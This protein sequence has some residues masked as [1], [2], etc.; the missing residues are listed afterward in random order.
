LQTSVNAKHKKMSSLPPGAEK[1]DHIGIAVKDLDAAEKTYTQLLGV[2]PYKRETVASQQ[3]V[4]SFFK[5]GESKI[6]LLSPTAPESPIAKFLENK[7][8]G[9]HHLAFG[10]KDI[11]AS[12]AK[13]KAQGFRLIH[14][15]PIQGADQ[16][17][18]AFVHP[19]D[20]TGALIELCEPLQQGL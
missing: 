13:L 2:P 15:T 4:T 7:G 17:L 12:L 10:V 6:E 3:V 20:T 8:E 11:V 18:I 9:I 5:I 14:E 1:I 19:K 16:K